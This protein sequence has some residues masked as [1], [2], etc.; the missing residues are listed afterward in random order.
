MKQ[1]Q[2]ERFIP[3]RKRDIFTLC[4]SIILSSSRDNKPNSLTANSDNQLDIQTG[5]LFGTFCQ[6][7]E[8]R[9]HY[10]YHAQLEHLK[11]CYHLLDPNKDTKALFALAPEQAKQDQHAFASGFAQLLDAA[12]YEKVTDNDLKAALEEESLFKV[13]LAVNFDDF[14]DVVFYR[15]GESERTETLRYFFGL[16]KKQISFTHYDRV[17]VYF[18]FKDEAYFESKGMKPVT[19]TPGS[20]LV[21]LFQNVPKADLEML[22]PNSE[23]KMRP[24]DKFII[25]ASAAIGGTV[26]LVTKLGASLILMGSFIAFWLG[27]KEEEVTLTQ[28]S[29]ITFGIGMGVFGSFVVRE[30]TKFK[31]RKIRF[32]KALSDNLYFKNLDNNAGVFHT[33]IDSAEEEDCKEAML[34]YSFLLRH[35]DN[36]ASA[37]A[38]DST[39][40]MWFKHEHHCCIDFDVADALNKLLHM[41]LVIKQDEVFV[42]RAL[43]DAVNILDEY[44]DSIYQSA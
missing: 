4:E 19:F 42:A 40:E 9:I 11:D 32:M 7:L 28:Q 16:R 17:A 39:I 22:F 44:W 26:V 29:L 2:L 36:G 6:L 23:V 34:A 30:W 25:S 18:T 43:P 10:Q 1:K 14:E 5:R 33:L 8:S 24:I 38:L 3:F 20:T 27:L 21:K 12:N 37:S 35:G 13:R 15:R 41:S 31:N